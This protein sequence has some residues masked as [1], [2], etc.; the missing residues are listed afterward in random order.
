MSPG[1]PLREGEQHVH[2]VFYDDQNIPVIGEVL[3]DARAEAGD[4]LWLADDVLAIGRGFRT[5]AKGVEQ[6]THIMSEQAIST[7][8]F[9]MP[10]YLGKEACLHLMSLISLV[11]DKQALVLLELVPVAL[12][13]L[14]LDMGYD[15][16]A[17]PFDE[18]ERTGTLSTNVL[19]GQ[20]WSRQVLRFKYLMAMHF[21]LAVR[22][23][24]LAL[25]GPSY[26]PASRGGLHNS[27]Q[28]ASIDVTIVKNALARATL[29]PKNNTKPTPSCQGLLSS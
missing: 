14:M 2:R 18:F 7:P 27:L 22:A 19:A 5:N 29:W 10:Y 16:I 21:V 1:K 9:D 11:G 20:H 6:L 26:V 3:G 15:I 24:P 8:A 25:H 28:C 13:Q 4:T 17:A 23:A 12:H